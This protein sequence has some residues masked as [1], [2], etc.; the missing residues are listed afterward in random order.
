MQG[1]LKSLAPNARVGVVGGGIS[2]LT[3][4]YFLAKLRPD[5]HVTVFESNP[6]TG[7]WIRSL[8][9]KDNEG[10]SI[11]LE[12]GPRTLRGVSD[13]TV[14]MADI[15]KDLK[16]HTLLQYV[17]KNSRANKK[18]LLDPNEIGRAHV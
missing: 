16:R 8:D 15:L 7:G 3:F 10:G 5:V 17:R 12:Q 4:S 13:G 9:T 11:M 18:F 14:L 1:P 6:R 2:G